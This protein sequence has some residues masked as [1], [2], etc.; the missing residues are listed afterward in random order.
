VDNVDALV[1]EFKQHRAQ[2]KSG[3]AMKEYGCRE[4]EIMTPEGRDI[5]F[6]E[7]VS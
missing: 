5:V 6:G 2:L 7:V 4:I 3:P 1:L